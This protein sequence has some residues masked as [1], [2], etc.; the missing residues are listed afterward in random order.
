[1]SEDNI[2]QY[3][4]GTE[5][6]NPLGKPPPKQDQGLPGSDWALP[7]I[8]WLGIK[9]EESCDISQMLDPASQ[10]QPDSQL[11]KSITNALNMPWEV[12]TEDESIDGLSLYGQLASLAR[13]IPPTQD[14]ER[15]TTTEGSSSAS[16][17][18]GRGSISPFT[19][20]SRPPLTPTL[21][22]PPSHRQNEPQ[23]PYSSPSRPPSIIKT[24]R[25]SPQQS[26]QQVPLSTPPLMTPPPKGESLT[27]QDDLDDSSD[28]S[29][30]PS[31]IIT[32]P[33]LWRG[34]TLEVSE[35][36]V[37]KIPPELR[38]G[39]SLKAPRNEFAPI[40]KAQLQDEHKPEDDVKHTTRVFFYWLLK[41]F[42]NHCR[43][44]GTDPHREWDLRMEVQYENNMILKSRLLTNTA[45]V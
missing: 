36:A 20:P 14:Y 32:P 4:R 33:G 34:K 6:K 37:I 28:L 16:G 12:I 43:D 24:P 19:S 7:Q 11:Q 29:S 17:S 40:P 41:H 8:E 30:P 21:R 23:S 26:R 27:F 3:K 31:V 25:P 2:R 42:L 1:M 10:F 5:A 38:Q 45:Q 35:S 44:N 15:S 39:N 22:T 18:E 13:I 9:L